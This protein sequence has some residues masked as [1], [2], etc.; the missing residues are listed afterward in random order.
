MPSGHDVSRSPPHDVRAPFSGWLGRGPGGPGGGGRGGGP[1]MGPAG[2]SPSFQHHPPQIRPRPAPRPVLFNL[3]SLWD[4]PDR[5]EWARQGAGGGRKRGRNS[6][7]QGYLGKP[8]A[9]PGPRKHQVPRPMRSQARSRSVRSRGGA[10]GNFL[11]ECLGGSAGA[12]TWG[13]AR[14]QDPYVLPRHPPD[15]VNPGSPTPRRAVLAPP[16]HPPELPWTLGH[17]LDQTAGGC[18]EE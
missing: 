18:L 3:Q 4:H 15:A 11:L 8:G 17:S 12:K 5:P 6:R 1:P 9:S 14:S 13:K 7:R 2:T 16:V 10:P